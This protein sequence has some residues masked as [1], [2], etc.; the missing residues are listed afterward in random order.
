LADEAMSK[1]RAH[2]SQASMDRPWPLDAWPNVM[3]R[4]VLC[5]EDRC[6]P[7]D[8]FRR[9]VAERLNITPDEIASGHCVALSRPRELA[10][11]LEGYARRPQASSASEPD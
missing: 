2:P 3:T 10:D 8:F 5:S 6:F 11:I 1:E 7:P 9:L 4:F